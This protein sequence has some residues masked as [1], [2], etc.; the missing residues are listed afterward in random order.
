MVA[1]SSS[2]RNLLIASLICY[3]L[4]AVLPPPATP[5]TIT[6]FLPLG[7]PVDTEAP[8]ILDTV[9]IKKMNTNKQVSRDY[10]NFLKR[11]HLGTNVTEVSILGKVFGSSFISSTSFTSLVF[12]ISECFWFKSNTVEF[13][14]ISATH[15]SKWVHVPYK[16]NT[17]GSGRGLD[18]RLEKG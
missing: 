15:H 16:S 11:I 6:I 5:P 17:S 9:T 3:Y 14:D 4:V 1:D 10:L 13:P 7:K 2:L 8:S 12:S 18:D